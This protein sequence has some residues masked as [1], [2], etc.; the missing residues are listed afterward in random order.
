MALVSQGNANG[1][2]PGRYCNAAGDADHGFFTPAPLRLYYRR[3]VYD[4]GRTHPR[5]K[6]ETRSMEHADPTDDTRPP[7]EPLVPA[8]GM[9]LHR[10]DM[11][12]TFAA[13]LPLRLA[14]WRLQEHGQWLP[15]DG[16]PARPIG[17]LVAENSTGPLRLGY[18]AWRDLLL[19]VQFRNGRGE[20]ITAGGRTV[21]NVA[22]YDL[23]KFMV[24]QHGVFGRIVTLTTRTY[25]R[26]AGALLVR[27]A[28]DPAVLARLLPTPLRPQWAVLTPDALLL[29]YL[30]D[31]T[32]IGWYAA[33]VGE[34]R[35]VEVSRRSVQEDIDQRA[36]LWRAAGPVRF[37]ATVPPAR[38]GGLRAIPVLGESWVADPAFGIMLGSLP[39]ERDLGAAREAF[40][41]LGGTVTFTGL[42]QTPGFNPSTNP[43][44]RQIIER[45]KQSFD[46]DNRLTPLPWQTSL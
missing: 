8:G 17:E 11:T 42:S 38:L 15:I 46:P 31:E 9:D 26:P 27:C 24:G 10:R 30:G 19:G 13:D 21:K 1:R 33:N 28:P 41:T 18:G 25:R 36:E 35:P 6:K 20:L 40:T 32:T 44:E 23:T 37:R 14:Q 39:G 12:A 3:H 4:V 22:G 7:R 16:D 34:S 43:V 45:L 5:L 2:V 29:G